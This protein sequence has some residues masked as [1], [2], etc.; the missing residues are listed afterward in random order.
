[1]AWLSRLAQWLGDRRVF[2]VSQRTSM[3]IF[4]SPPR[5]G[6]ELLP[7]LPEE[8]LILIRTDFLYPSFRYLPVCITLPNFG[9]LHIGPFFSAFFLDFPFERL[10]LGQ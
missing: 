2:A 7:S 10:L 9:Y 4:C 6:G 1:M 8:T 3:M 5:G